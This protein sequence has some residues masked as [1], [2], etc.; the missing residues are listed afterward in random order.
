M[1]HAIGILYN[2]I[3]LDFQT[4]VSTNLVVSP[5]VVSTLPVDMDMNTPPTSSIT[6]HFSTS[7]HRGL[8]EGS[9]RSDDN[10][11]L[12]DSSMITQCFEN[13]CII[14]LSSALRPNTFYSLELSPS[15]FVNEYNLPLDRSIHI[16]FKTGSRSCGVKMIQ[17]GLGSS[18]MCSCF[19]E[20]DGCSCECGDV[21]VNRGF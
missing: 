15:F 17:D 14:Q 3:I 6:I 20:H 8:G 13:T 5:Q 10:S 4:F 1:P 18:H 2:F 11:V 12:F 9:L 19:S 7:M 21:Q 16:V